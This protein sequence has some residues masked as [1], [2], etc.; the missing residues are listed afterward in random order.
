MPWVLTLLAA[1]GFASTN[2][3]DAVAGRARIASESGL[4][5]ERIGQLR[6]ER[7]GISDMRPVAGIEIELQKA[8]TEAQAVWRITDGCR[9][10]TRPAW[11]DP[12]DGSDRDDDNDDAEPG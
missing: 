9:D 5:T 6:R 8:Q 1:M 3:G 4:L 11:L 10:V 12:G 7:A 2:I